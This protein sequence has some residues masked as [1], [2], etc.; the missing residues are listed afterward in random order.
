MVDD[1]SHVC[2]TEL[3]TERGHRSGICHPC[4]RL[5]LES[6]Q[7]SSQMLGRV[8]RLHGG[9]PGERGEYTRKA[10]AGELVASGAVVAEDLSTPRP[11]SGL[12]CRGSRGRSLRKRGRGSRNARRG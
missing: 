2:V 7:N 11:P 5:A 4:D 8:T 1:R 9:A 12:G 10:L 3:R 6:P